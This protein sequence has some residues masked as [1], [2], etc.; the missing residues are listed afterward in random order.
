MPAPLPGL[1]RGRSKFNQR[2]GA[3]SLPPPLQCERSGEW[4]SG[5]SFVPFVAFCSNFNAPGFL[6]EGNGG[7]EGTS[8]ETAHRSLLVL[9]GR[10]LVVQDVSY[11]LQDVFYL[12]QNCYFVVQDVS[13][14]A[15]NCFYIVQNCPYIA[16][17]RYYIAQNCPYLDVSRPL[18]DEN[19]GLARAGQDRC[20]EGR[21][22]KAKA[23]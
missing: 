10:N 20:A 16:Q 22:T 6:T 23:Q 1:L 4:A 13:Y 9:L 19:R 12:A 7:D 3:V 2:G 8:R 14:I 11:I 5:S 18:H 21:R 15:Q 17:N